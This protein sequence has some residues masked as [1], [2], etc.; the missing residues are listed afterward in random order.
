MLVGAGQSASAH[1][2]FE[3]VTLGKT[4]ITTTRLCFGT[5]V[6]AWNR[7]SALLRKLGPDDAAKLIRAA[8][9]RGV[10][11]FDT[12]DAYGTHSF[13][14][15]AL[16]GVPRDSYAICT[17]FAWNGGIPKDE[18][19][20]VATAIDRYLKELGTD[21]ID[22][23]Q[24]HC[25]TDAEWPKKLSKHMD[26]LEAA[27]RAG[28]IRAHG[29]SFHSFAALETAAKTP[30]LDVAHVRIN[31]FGR[32][33]SMHP[34]KVLPVLKKMRAQGQGIIG[35]K[36]LGEGTFSK[37]SAKIDASIAY[38]LNSGAADVINIGF[39]SIGEVDDIARRIASVPLATASGA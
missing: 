9:D 39:L 29:C 7:T 18:R 8:Y 31:P 17:K 13:V 38:A 24:L 19:T 20:D 10:R 25:L 32:K 37:E 23:V 28:K 16:K 2:A 11:F 22:I 26:G 36:I 14:Y 4:G 34:E 1:S 35:M 12:A 21:Y 15:N 6:S 30:W 3:K 33:M 27:K 5:G